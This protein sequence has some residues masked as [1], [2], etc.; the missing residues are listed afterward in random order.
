VDWKAIAAFVTLVTLANGGFVW[1][2]KSLLAA[3]RKKLIDDLKRIT[4]EN[5]KQDSRHKPFK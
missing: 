1:A 2:V 5:C 3:D 4:D